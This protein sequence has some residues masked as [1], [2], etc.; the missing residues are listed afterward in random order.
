M[1]ARADFDLKALCPDLIFVHAVGGCDVSLRPR[2][3]FI[4]TEDWFFAERFLVM[5]QV[6]KRCGFDVS[7]IA[8]ERTHRAM[9]EAEGFTLIPL[10]AER[11]S[12]NPVAFLLATWRLRSIL[13]T[14]RPD[15]VHCIAMKSI[16]MGGLA[17]N[18]AGI[19]QRVFAPTGL[20]VFADGTVPLAAWARR[21]LAWLIRRKLETDQT[22]YLCEN[23]SD[24]RALGLDPADAGKVRIAGGAGI[25]PARFTPSP[26]PL[27]PPLKIA[28]VS[29]MLA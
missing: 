25:D 24:P 2:L 11:R 29:R 21:L 14:L 17:S 7:V 15:V 18:S 26:L 20:G 13:K 9:I 23:L 16:V 19:E 12:V 1:S 27:L 22:T 6:A 3:A 8:R 28:I 10:E 4:V 5:G